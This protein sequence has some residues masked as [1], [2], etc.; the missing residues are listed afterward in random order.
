MREPL[1]GWGR[2]VELFGVML[3]NITRIIGSPNAITH[4]AICAEADKF[5]AYFMEGNFG[6]RQYDI[7]NSRYQLLFGADPIAA[8]RQ[9]SFATREWGNMLDRAKVAVVDPRF[10]SNAQKADEWLPLK[11]GTDSALVSGSAAI[12]LLRPQSALTE[13]A[14]RIFRQTLLLFAAL[15]L[16][17][18]SMRLTARS[19]V[20]WAGPA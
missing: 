3:A 13:T 11:P 7:K 10:S 15:I 1:S 8:N 20:C 4:S 5:G 16:F 6:Y 9:V 14:G 2:S 12:V 17:A 18:W 19:R